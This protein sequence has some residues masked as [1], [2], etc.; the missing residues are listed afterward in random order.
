MCVSCGW[1][2]WDAGQQLHWGKDP[3]FGASPWKSGP[4]STFQVPR[5]LSLDT[6][7]NQSAA[8]AQGAVVSHT[9]ISVP[10][11]SPQS[12][13]ASEEAPAQINI[14]K[15]FPGNYC[16]ADKEVPVLI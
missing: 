5:G 6:K 13:S 12:A 10:V 14:P 1:S 9:I 7:D 11:T 16:N 3:G 8:A 2:M 15:P 4:C